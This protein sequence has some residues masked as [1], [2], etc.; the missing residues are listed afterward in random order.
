MRPDVSSESSAPPPG[1][2]HE[3]VLLIRS[4]RHLRVAMDALERRYPGC[5]IGVIGTPGSE[6]AAAQAGVGPADYFYYP[7]SRIRPVA[8]L[9]SKAARSARSWGFTRVAIL[10]QDPD[11]TGQGNV[12][13]TALALSPF[14]FLA[15]TPDGTIIERSTWRQARTECAR[16]AASLVV[17]TALG[18][19]LYGPA[20]I[21][22][23]I[24]KVA[25]ALRGNRRV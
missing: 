20:R 1:T 3:R 9:A 8:L 21:A 6:H 12:N 25:I 2:K 7:G 22:F 14:G 5:A 23:Y 24:R 19:L 13:R 16:A 17:G 4:A 11:G 10:W 15:I 18:A